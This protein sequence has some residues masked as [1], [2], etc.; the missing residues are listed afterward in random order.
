VT[1]IPDEELWAA[2]LRLKYKLARFIRER[3]RLRWSEDRVDPTQVVAFGA[4]L[5]PEAMTIGFA[6]RFAT[7]KRATL[8]LRDLKRLRRLLTD[9]SRPVQ[10]LFAGKAHP[11]DE[12]GKQLLQAV[13]RAARDPDLAG[14]LAFVEDYDMHVAHYLVQGVDLWLNTPRPPLE[15]SGTSGMKAALNGIPSLSVL[16]GWWAEGHDGTNGWAF[17]E[18]SAGAPADLDAKDAADAERLYALLEG[19]VVPL[20]YERDADGLPA[21]WLGVVRRAIRTNAPVF[22]T[23]RMLKQYADRFYSQAATRGRSR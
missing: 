9:R 7:Y 18:E 3:A 14:R 1:R 2:R 10:L 5:D 19:T 12:P 16:D 11:A 13:Y 4:L 23:R 22:S 6:R 21:A 17:G 8:I 15:A 20:Y